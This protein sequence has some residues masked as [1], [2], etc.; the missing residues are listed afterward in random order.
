MQVKPTTVSVGDGSR[1]GAAVG[2]GWRSASFE[3][4]HEICARLPAECRYDVESAGARSLRMTRAL[5]RSPAA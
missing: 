1:K 3:S 4:K 2:L 5:G